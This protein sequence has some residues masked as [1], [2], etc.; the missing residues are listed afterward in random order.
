MLKEKSIFSD[1]K[2]TVQISRVKFGVLSIN[3]A[4]KQARAYHHRLGSLRLSFR[5]SW[6]VRCLLG[7]CTCE[8]KGRKQD[9]EVKEAKLQGRSKE[10]L[11]QS[12]GSSET[13]LP[14]RVV[15]VAL[16]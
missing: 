8:R 14:I 3:K 1:L 2:L 13:T 7:L 12:V 11:V 10:A 15:F 9:L 6:G 4:T 16:K 5:W